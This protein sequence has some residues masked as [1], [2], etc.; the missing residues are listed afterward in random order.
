M[1]ETHPGQHDRVLVENL[2]EVLR[3]REAQAPSAERARTIAEIESALA[4][5]GEL[6]GLPEVLDVIEQSS[7]GTPEAR[8]L[9]RQAS[10]VQIAD[11]LARADRIA[12][13]SPCIRANRD[14]VADTVID[15][16]DVPEEGPIA[17]WFR[18]VRRLCKRPGY[19]RDTMLMDLK[20]MGFSVGSKEFPNALLSV[21]VCPDRVLVR[22]FVTV[23]GEDWTGS[24]FEACYDAALDE[25]RRL[26]GRH[27]AAGDRT[28]L[29]GLALSGLAGADPPMQHLLMRQ[30][31]V[32]YSLLPRKV[33][34]RAEIIAALVRLLDTPSTPP[35]VLYGGGGSGKSTVA[36]QVAVA[37]RDRGQRVWWVQAGDSN[38]VTR[39]I[40]AVATQLDA[41]V[42]ELNAIQ[43]NPQ[44]GAELLWRRLDASDTRWL[45]VFDGANHP[46]LLGIPAVGEAPI[47]LRPSLRGT[48]LVTTRVREPG[49]WGQQ[50]VLTEIADLSEEAG[51]QVVLDLALPDAAQDGPEQ[52][53]HARQ[54]SRRLGG[55]AFALRTVGTYVGSSVPGHDLAELANTLA[56][57]NSSGTGR[58]TRLE[59]AWQLAMS[60]LDRCGV[61]EARPL[62]RVLS[63]YAP[64]WIVP[65]DVLAPGRLAKACLPLCSPERAT[66]SH[67]WHRALEGL[68]IVGLIDRKIADGEQVEGIV[69]HPLVAE[70]SRAQ[71]PAGNDAE[72]DLIV[73][74]AVNI[75][76]QATDD[77][78][79]GRPAHWPALRRLEPH[80]YALLDKEN[81]RADV[82]LRLAIRIA[83]GLIHS[84]LFAVGEELI[85]HARDCAIDLDTC[86]E[87]TFAAEHTLAHALG[88]R[89]ELDEAARRYRDL[90]PRLRERCG[91][92]HHLTLLVR[93]HLAWVLAEQGKLEEAHRRFCE[94]LP[95]CERVLGVNDR[96]TLAARH[97]IAWITG[98]M[99]DPHAAEKMFASVLPQREEVLGKDHMDVM[100]TRYRLAWARCKQGRYEAGEADYLELLED[101][102]RVLDD[103]DAAAVIMARARLGWVRTWLGRFAEAERDY[104]HVLE[105]RERVLGRHHAMSLET[106]HDMAWLLSHK[107]DY[108][109]AERLFREVL[110]EVERIPELGRDHP[111]ALETRGRLARLLSDTGQL[112][113][114]ERLSRAIVTQRTRVSG[115]RHPTTLITR[116]ILGRTLMLGGQLAE[117]ERLLEQVLAD[118]YQLIG[119]EHPYTLETRAAIAELIGQQGRLAQTHDLIVDV[120]RIRGE[121]LGANHPDT[122]YSREQQVW[123]LGELQ[124]LADAQTKCQ[125]LIVDRSRVLGV[126]HPDTLAARYRLGWLLGLAG[127]GQDA[128]RVYRALVPDQH[129][130]LGREHPHTLRSRH[131]L[132]Q[133]L[134]RSGQLEEGELALRSVL[135]D[136]IHLLGRTHPDTLV[137]WHSLAVVM[138]MR[139]DLPGAEEAMQGVL[140]HQREVLGEGHRN[141]LVTR[142]RLLWIQQRR[143][144][145][146][147]PA[148]HWRQLLHERERRLGLDHPETARIRERLASPDYAVPYLW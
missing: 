41:P 71:G 60:G 120:L 100:T 92:E 44:E 138:A 57:A 127:R 82:A 135:L 143:G 115:P 83:E 24:G 40:L 6:T 106:R 19:D 121:V 139:G 7:L 99:G 46:E 49:F 125:S 129:R 96:Q 85:R 122:L 42:S 119:A 80:V 8:A 131:G 18:E 95:V 2:L 47:W 137:N 68:I 14:R 34:G 64:N 123:V 38:Q 62:M 114:A 81:A 86:A 45:L 148:E 36:R 65:L 5:D 84:G 52:L 61:P 63:C 105:T 147:N 4:G 31:Q 140:R 35:Q 111:L 124:R 51:A 70:L 28:D 27:C 78:D 50:A 9:R 30:V 26:D 15:D 22:A 113:E 43:A 109:G 108:R 32:D 53:E 23:L 56:E 59:A 132:A 142:E 104:R 13:R 67:V 128:Q 37:A 21:P 110:S 77:L 136:R 93:D 54:V 102:E 66:G 33:R 69:M 94:L 20:G 87:E 117:A 98:L 12:A 88:L 141:T 90:L 17:D 116:F 48:V 118:Q 1:T 112:G 101:L 91:E 146:D 107:G 74:A 58:Q 25:Q 103:P 3:L 75:L 79:A 130:V 73:T 89:R 134:V 72:T 16:Q 10:P 76:L 29:S 126:L 145:L 97:R 144:L 39:G 133:E 11:V 55:V